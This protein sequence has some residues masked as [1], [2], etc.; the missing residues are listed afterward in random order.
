MVV[1]MIKTNLVIK[2]PSKCLNQNSSKNAICNITGH[3]KRAI[4]EVIATLMLLAI[5]VIGGVIV[6]NFFQSSG[7]SENLGSGFS[8]GSLQSQSPQSIILTGYDTRD[9]NDLF[10]TVLDNKYDSQLCTIGCASYANNTPN[11]VPAG[12]EGTEFIVLKI[13]ND[14][15]SSV[16][17]NDLLVNNVDHLL[18][19]TVTT[20][21]LDASV[22]LGNYPDAGKFSI[23]ST[24]DNSSIISSNELVG[25][26]E[27]LLVI[28][29]SKDVTMNSGGTPLNISLN[30]PLIISILTESVN[31]PTFVV[32]SGDVM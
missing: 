22:N 10:A 23:I 15:L 26:D 8:P 21:V 7:I 25:G 14:G 5:T 2:K 20:G 13:K 11:S 30:S 6:A 4:S 18:D 29:L 32:A 27:V 19:T 12:T 16:F 28:K 17:L 1:K 9:H 24:T 3:K 31:N